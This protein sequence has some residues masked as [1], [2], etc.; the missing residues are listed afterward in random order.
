MKV[1]LLTQIAPEN[2]LLNR[3]GPE[4]KMAQAAFL[5]VSF[6]QRSGM[7][8]L[9]KSL[10]PLLDKSRPVAI[11]T[12]GYLGITDPDALEDLLRLSGR[13]Q[14]LHVFFNPEDRFHSKFFFF[15]EGGDGYSLFLGSSNISVGGFA[16]TGELNVCI[17]S[18]SA[19]SVHRDIQIVMENLK[20]NRRFRS[21]RPELIRAYRKARGSKKVRRGTTRQKRTQIT[22]RLEE[23]PVYVVYNHFNDKESE[24]IEGKHPKWDNY[25]SYSAKLKRLNKGDHF[26]CITKVGGEKATFTASRYVEHDRIAGVGTVACVE[27]GDSLAL[28]RLVKH[29]KIRQK[30]LVRMRGLDVYGIAIL[31]RD[32]PKTFA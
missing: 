25:V 12:S 10:Q 5:A 23:M 21:L 7:K 29:L 19:D 13:Y 17:R 14:S 26:L 20:R 22:P 32:F 4:A 15:E 6:V 24:R 18:K 8:H 16:D 28:S 31:R 2:R 11:Y 3:I 1:S 27:D 9:F 30:E